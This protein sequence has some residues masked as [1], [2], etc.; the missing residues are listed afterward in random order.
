MPQFFIRMRC[1]VE[2]MVTVEGCTEEEARN[3]P[4]DYAIDQYETGQ[5]DWEILEVR[6]E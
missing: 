2:K 6:K 4:W 1:T 5:Y 3:N